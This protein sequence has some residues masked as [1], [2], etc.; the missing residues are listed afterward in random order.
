ME[1][2]QNRKG[3]TSLSGRTPYFVQNSDPFEVRVAGFHVPMRE[4]PHLGRQRGLLNYAA[5]GPKYLL[6]Q[7]F[8]AVHTAK[9]SAAVTVQGTDATSL[10]IVATGPR[11]TQ[12]GPRRWPNHR[13]C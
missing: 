10:A 4:N 7:M 13:S 11:T 5:A 3:I 2:F 8:A 1:Q 12:I 9:P 6:L